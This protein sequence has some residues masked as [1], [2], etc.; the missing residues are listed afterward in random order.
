M[1]SPAA[2]RIA[3]Q[4]DRAG[5][6]GC[7]SLKSSALLNAVSR[8]VL[9]AATSTRPFESSVAVWSARPTDSET[10]VDQAFMAGS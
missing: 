9:P 4:A 7:A 10:V 3:A 2:K 1:A 6:V 5:T 8:P